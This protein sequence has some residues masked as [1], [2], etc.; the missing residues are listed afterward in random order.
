MICRSSDRKRSS[1]AAIS[2][3]MA[4]G[5]PVSSAALGDRRDQLLGEQRV[6]ACPTADPLDHRLG[7]PA[8]AAQRA[9]QSRVRRP[10]SRGSSGSDMNARRPPPQVGRRSSSSG[11]AWA[12]ISSGAP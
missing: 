2:A 12:T 7:Q 6:A 9:R 5:M 1:R 4:E 11:R 3:L 8:L 10:R